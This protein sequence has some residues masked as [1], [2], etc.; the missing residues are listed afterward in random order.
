MSG[1]SSTN[2]LPRPFLKWVGGKR[3]LLPELLRAVESAGPF[4][5]YHEPFLGGGALFF[6]LARRRQLN[7]ISYLSDVSESIIHA[8]LGVRDDVGR[9]IKHL[10]VH[11]AKH[12]KKYYYDMRSSSPRTSATRA[13]R[14]IYLNKTCYNGLHRENS[15]GLFNAPMGSYENPKI[16]DAENLLAVSASLSQTQISAC[17]FTTVEKHA[18]EGDLIYFDPPY[19]PIS[20]TA[21]FTSYSRYDFGEDA[22]HKLANVFRELDKRGIKLILSNSMTEFIQSLYSDFCITTVLAKRSVNSKGDRRGQIP[23]ALI[24]NFIMSRQS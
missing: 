7:G 17:S 19:H 14:I 9:V 6:E 18:K 21:S 22:Q 24:T 16:C 5:R 12:C 13:A 20:K 4:G 2:T 1:N 3:Q 15:K 23:E 11:K 8:Y 10:K